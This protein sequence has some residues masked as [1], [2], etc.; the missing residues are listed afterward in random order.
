[1][2]R[3]RSRFF[4]R[5]KRTRRGTCHLCVDG[6]NQRKKKDEEFEGDL[7]QKGIAYLQQRNDRGRSRL[8]EKLK[9]ESSSPKG[10]C[11]M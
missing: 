11:L 10:G 7:R 2:K 9:A 5:K 6:S 4:K 1:M 3:E 8:G